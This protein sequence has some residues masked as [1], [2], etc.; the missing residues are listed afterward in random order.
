[1][2]V[3]VKDILQNDLNKSGFGKGELQ[4][5]VALHEHLNASVPAINHFDLLDAALKQPTLFSQKPETL[6][7]NVVESARLMQVSEAAFVAAALKQPQL[8]CQKP[9]TLHGKL[10]YCVSI[11]EALGQKILPAAVFVSFPIALAYSHT[12]L[13][14]RYV[15][16]KLNLRRGGY[17]SF[18]T[19][20]AAKAQAL[21]TKHFERQIAETGKGTR[22]LQVMHAQ[23]IIKELPDGIQP[24]VRP[25]R[26]A[27]SPSP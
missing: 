13:H 16:A 11:F 17:T 26:R 5:L 10:P 21:I 8:F 20:S 7:G 2:D 19:L 1:M 23:G 25:P 27:N 18:V 4:A 9:E 22:A 3:S 14:A 12:H 15:L 24:I 6:H